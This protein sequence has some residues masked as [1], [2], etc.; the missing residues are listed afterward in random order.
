MVI[1]TSK[2]VTATLILKLL[3]VISESIR[4]FTSIIWNLDTPNTK[5]AFDIKVFDIKGLFDIKLTVF[6][7]ECLYD[8]KCSTFDI[9][10]TSYDIIVA[11]TTKS[12]SRMIFDIKSS[13]LGSYIKEP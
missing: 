10:I 12:L 9:D 5:G 2:R 1:S 11:K 8:I 3:P 4:M 7:I 13:I 6:D